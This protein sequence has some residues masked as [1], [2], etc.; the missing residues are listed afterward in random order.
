MHRV[1]KPERKRTP[2]RTDTGNREPGCRVGKAAGTPGTRGAVRVAHTG[3]PGAKT[4]ACTGAEAPWVLAR[5]DSD[6]R[7]Q[8]PGLQGPQ[9]SLG[10][11]TSPAPLANLDPDGTLVR[12][13]HPAVHPAGGWGPCGRCSWTTGAVSI[14]D[15]SPGPG[16][17][18]PCGNSGPGALSHVAHLGKPGSLSG[19]MAGPE[20][21]QGG[22]FPG[23]GAECKGW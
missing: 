8:K 19:T 20:D 6:F 15:P 17:K 4:Q 13:G 12:G 1:R 11:S 14:R 10:S 18:H 2:R 22:Q 21:T 16:R 23:T 7:P 3:T 9:G 5:R